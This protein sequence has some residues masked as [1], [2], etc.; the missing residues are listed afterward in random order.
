MKLMDIIQKR[1]INLINFQQKHISFMIIFFLIITSI[2]FI[3]IS[4]LE[5]ESDFS[6]F[7]PKGL[8][9]TDLDL[10]AGKMFSS[11]QSG[12][13]IIVRLDDDLKVQ[14]SQ[15]NDIRDPEVIKF[16]VRLENNLMQESTVESVQSIGSVFSQ[17]PVPDSIDQVKVILNNIPGLENSISSDYS[18]TPAF[19]SVFSSSEISRIEA[20]NQRIDEIVQLSNPPSGI[21]TTV[22]GDP[23]LGSLLFRFLIN[24]A[25]TV[26]VIALIFIFI[27]LYITQRSFKSSLTIIIPLL[28]GLTWTVGALGLLKIPITVATAGL[29]AMLLGL[30]VEYSI[31]LYSRYKEERQTKKIEESI[32]LAVSNV[33]TSLISSGGTTAIGFFA[34]SISVFPML[35]QLGTSLGIGILMLL[36]ATIGLLPLVILLVNKAESYFNLKKTIKKDK[37]KFNISKYF[38]AY[39]KLVSTKPLITLIL[40]ILVTVAMFAGMSRVEQSDINFRTVLP[41]DIEELKAF[42]LLED[43][44]GDRSGAKIFVYLDPS[45]PNSNEPTDIRDLEILNYVDILSQKAKTIT[46]VQSVSSV[47]ESIKN[48][49]GYLPS[50]ISS[51]KELFNNPFIRNS[52]TN[53]FSGTLIRITLNEKGNSE[54]F[55]ISR[56]INELIDNTQKPIGVKAA[57]IGEIPVIAEQN[58]FVGEDS[59][60]TSILALIVIIIFLF[61]LTRSFKGTFLPLITVIL[62]VI[63]TMGSIGFFRIPFTSITSSVITMTIGIGIDFGLQLMTRYDYE[64]QFNKKR[65]AMEITIGNILVPMILTVIAAVIGF[66]A[67]RFGNLSL[68]ADLGNTMGLAITVSMIASVTGVASIMVLLQKDKI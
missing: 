35:S 18:F 22:T 9:I 43:E 10:E 26:L 4:K 54:Y 55:E 67:M 3:G 28:F 7:N 58:A 20:L 32:K 1:L 61:L 62:G 14:G 5:I 64:L 27:L 66:S 41:Q 12:I 44:F 53:D 31:F 15:I 46:H 51:N 29:S 19:V 50:T 68:M 8:P 23:A 36:L 2:A 6:K 40:A 13:V 48:V 17:M 65:K 60:K 59:S 21:K 57:A 45:I 52:M 34:L 25:I 56:Q 47:T 49:N 39:G 38:F 11:G 42:N 16:L 37:Q 33:G 24:D 30:G 63:W